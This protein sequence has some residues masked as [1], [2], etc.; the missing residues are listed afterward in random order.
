MFWN[1]LGSFI[2]DTAQ[3]GS[4]AIT[5]PIMNRQWQMNDGKERKRLIAFVGH[6]AREFA[7]NAT[8]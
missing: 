5:I 7:A 3:R 1:P 8:M 6:T 4:T 2:I